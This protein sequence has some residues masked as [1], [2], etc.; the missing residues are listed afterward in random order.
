[1]LTSTPKPGASS[2][3]WIVH[4]APPRGITNQP[5]AMSGK[6]VESWI[7]DERPFESA[8]AAR[9]VDLSLPNANGDYRW[10]EVDRD[11]LIAYK[12]LRLAH[13][14]PR[15]QVAR[16]VSDVTDCARRRDGLRRSPRGARAA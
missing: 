3:W 7:S 8:A 11:P 10:I 13:V 4:E 6:S 14:G 1:M 12:E 15:C 5:A 2:C 9:R 16:I